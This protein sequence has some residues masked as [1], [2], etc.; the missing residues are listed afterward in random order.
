V[1]IYCFEIH[2][3]A[4]VFLMEPKLA[5]SIVLFGSVDPN[6]LLCQYQAICDCQL[7][8]SVHG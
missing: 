6:I 3:L 8:R 7:A 1:Q 2:S 5:H 4:Q